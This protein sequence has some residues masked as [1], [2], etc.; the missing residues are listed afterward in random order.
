M[1]DDADG[2]G[3]SSGEKQAGLGEYYARPRRGGKTG[4]RVLGGQ[5]DREAWEPDGEG[6]PSMVWEEMQV[7]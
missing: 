3:G 1:G 2:D 6:C 7:W 4:V 5:E